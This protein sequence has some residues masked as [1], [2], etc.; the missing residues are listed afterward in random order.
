M[1]HAAQ[2]VFDVY[3]EDAAAGFRLDYFQA[4]N[5]GTFHERIGHA[6]LDGQTTLLTGENGA[7]KS[8][9]ADGIV[10]LL[11]P[12]NKRNYNAASSDAKRER[13]E[14]DYIRG[15]IGTTYNELHERDEP[16]FLRP[17][18]QYYTVLLG[19][20]RNGRENKSV[21][22]AQILWIKSNGDTA[23][24][25]IIEPRALT[26]VGDLAGFPSIAAIKETLTDRGI[27]TV[28]KFN[29]Y[30]ERFHRLL[31]LN[32][33]RNP[34][35]IFNQTVAVKDIKNLTQFIRD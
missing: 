15:N 25:F 26:I 23:K 1:T 3:Q 27:E 17:D 18:G 9:L 22:L 5:W 35:N 20:F 34:M 19:V 33:D 28:D 12:T 14:P 29:I 13:S 21:T 6:R 31:R 24:L 16:V 8:T 7:G 10:T 11:V 4:Y 2:D 32:A 30:S